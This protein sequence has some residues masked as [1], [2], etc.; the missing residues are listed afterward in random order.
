ML[1][2]PQL[3]AATSPPI[4]GRRPHENARETFSGKQTNRH[5]EHEQEMGVEPVKRLMIRLPDPA[6]AALAAWRANIDSSAEDPREEL[7]FHN[8]LQ[9]LARILDRIPG[10][11]LPSK[12]GTT[13]P[14]EWSRSGSGG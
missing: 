11:R 13:M 9:Q 1:M 12:V 10:L 2:Y 6:H 8:E 14:A 3:A 5:I 4:K 7:A